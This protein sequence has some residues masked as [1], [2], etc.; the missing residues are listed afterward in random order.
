MRYAFTSATCPTCDTLF[1]S[2][3]IDYDEEG[4]YVALMVTP[5]TGCGTLLC[6]AS[7]WSICDECGD[8]FCADC[9]Q[10]VD[11]GTDSSLR[12]CIKCVREGEETQ[13][14]LLPLPAVAAYCVPLRAV[15]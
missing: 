12:C 8:V 13:Q 15:A 4:G 2:L 9:L 5:C 7:D 10:L 3:A 11:D 6:S 1:E 14:D